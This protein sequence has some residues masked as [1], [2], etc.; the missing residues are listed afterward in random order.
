MSRNTFQDQ[1]KVAFSITTMI[2][3]YFLRLLWSTHSLWI[4]P[5]FSN[6][7]FPKLNPAASQPPEDSYSPTALAWHYLFLLNHLW[8]FPLLPPTHL[9]HL[10]VSS[11]LSFS[12]SEGLLSQPSFPSTQPERSTVCIVCGS[13]F[14]NMIFKAHAW[15]HSIPTTNVITAV[16]QINRWK[17]SSKETMSHSQG[18]SRSFLMPS[19]TTTCTEPQLSSQDINV[20]SVVH[21]QESPCSFSL[22]RHPPSNSL[23]WYQ[24]LT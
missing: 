20:I 2:N 11:L 22:H 15:F 10:S 16:E 18:A 5:S 7:A 12:L 9:L 3:T 6:V 24:G 23:P 8:G 21:F 17:I 4:S 1:G 13:A 14:D 19:L